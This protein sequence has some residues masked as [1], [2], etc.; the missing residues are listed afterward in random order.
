MLIVIWYR[1]F[2]GDNMNVE[3]NK[4]KWKKLIFYF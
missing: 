4:E 2:V 3:L 1:N